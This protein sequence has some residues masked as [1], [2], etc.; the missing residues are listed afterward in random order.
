MDIRAIVVKI[1]EFCDES[2]VIRAKGASFCQVDI[3][4]PVVRSRPCNTSGSQMWR[5]A[6]PIFSPRAM[7]IIVRGRGWES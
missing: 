1:S 4:K 2:W 6:R 5:G 7:V 3:S